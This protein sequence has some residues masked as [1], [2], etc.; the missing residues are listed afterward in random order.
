MARILVVDDVPITR[1]RLAHELVEQD[2]EVLVASG[3]REA[4]R[5]ASA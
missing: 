2:H 4:I 3:G 5:M 1:K